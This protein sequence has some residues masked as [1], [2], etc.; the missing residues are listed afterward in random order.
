MKPAALLVSILLPLAVQAD[1]DGLH[2]P[3]SVTIEASSLVCRACPSTDCAT[4]RS[5]PKGA[6]VTVLCTQVGT[7]IE[8]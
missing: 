5:Y 1:D 4:A 2:V 6:K 7:K 3:A 8:G